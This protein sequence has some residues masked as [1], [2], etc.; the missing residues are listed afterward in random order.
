M[1]KNLKNKIKCYPDPSGKNRHTSSLATDHDILRQMGFDVR[2]KRSAPAVIDRVNAV[3]K[4]ME[5]CIID[6]KCKGFIR[7]LEQT[8]NKE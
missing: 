5:S 4:I 1:Y 8:N 6:P 7:D 3:N 2:V